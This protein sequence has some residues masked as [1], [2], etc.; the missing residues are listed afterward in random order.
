M[1]KFG[2]RCGYVMNLSVGWSDYELTLISESAV[3]ALAE[4]VGTGGP[5]TSEQFFEDF[6]RHATA[7]YRCPKCNRIYIEESSGEFVIY[8]QESD[9]ID[10][11]R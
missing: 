10:A 9:V 7:V 8:I 5:M 3:E 4:R 2:C 1:S 6:D 11:S